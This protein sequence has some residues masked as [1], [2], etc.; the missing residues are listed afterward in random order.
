MVT[1]KNSGA[2]LLTI[3]GL[4]PRRDNRPFTTDTSPDDASQLPNPV[5]ARGLKRRR[6]GRHL[7]PVRKA[8]TSFYGVARDLCPR[9]SAVRLPEKR[10]EQLQV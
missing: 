9:L 6:R 3:S 4:T 2:L 8:R 10:Q 1:G 5:N 7:H